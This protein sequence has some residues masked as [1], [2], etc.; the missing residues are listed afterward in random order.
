[1]YHQQFEVG[2]IAILRSLHALSGLNGKEVEI[3]GPLKDRSVY[4]VY[5]KTEKTLAAYHVR[6][7]DGFEM[8]AQ[9]YQLK[10]RRPDP[11]VVVRETTIPWADC[12]FKP[13]SVKS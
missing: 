13:K 2:E 1:M 10:K 7:P 12:V 11:P 9:P 8:A 4:S 6:L 5:T 3:L